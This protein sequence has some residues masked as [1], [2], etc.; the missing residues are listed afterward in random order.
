L[1]PLNAIA[2]ILSAFL[3]LRRAQPTE[4]M[5]GAALRRPV[6]QLLLFEAL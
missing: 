4:V 2:G 6:C 5:C 3:F 1:R